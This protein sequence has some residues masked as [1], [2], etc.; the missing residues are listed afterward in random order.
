MPIK[1]HTR[2]DFV[3]PLNSSR[4]RSACGRIPDSRM[5]AYVV[6]ARCDALIQA[7][8]ASPGLLQPAVS[9]MTAGGLRFSPG[10]LQH[11]VMMALYEPEMAARPEPNGAS[12]I[13]GVVPTATTR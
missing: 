3:G 6:C 12:D 8:S 13:E 2:V 11:D 1:A 7:P 9:N 4:S 10:A 5:G